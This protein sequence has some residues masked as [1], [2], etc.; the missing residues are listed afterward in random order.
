MFGK[1]EQVLT[2][3]E[4]SV[5]NDTNLEDS[6][7]SEEENDNNFDGGGIGELPEEEVKEPMSSDVDIPDEKPFMDEAK[8]FTD[9][10]GQKG[11]LD[12]ILDL[13]K[14][15]EEIWKKIF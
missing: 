8:R 3:E 15:V 2:E 13:D 1:K 14:K 6:V 9:R 10:F 7:K 4:N 5:E 12:V 11:A